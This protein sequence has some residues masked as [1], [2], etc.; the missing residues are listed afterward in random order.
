MM[1]KDREG[2]D[3]EAEDSGRAVQRRT[4]KS[5]NNLPSLRMHTTYTNVIFSS[6]LRYWAWAEAAWADCWPP[7]ETRRAHLR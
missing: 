2:E 3:E 4:E 5:N 1:V 7:L 6:F